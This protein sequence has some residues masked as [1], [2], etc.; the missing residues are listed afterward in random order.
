M[1]Q[2]GILYQLL[3]FLL[4]MV[5]GAALC[6]IYDIFRIARIAKK[7]SRLLLFMQ[8]IAFA[9]VCAVLIFF[10]QMVRSSGEVRWFILTGALCGFAACRVTV[11]RFFML[12]SGVIIRVIK[13][14]IEL[15]NKLLICPVTRVINFILNFLIL[16]LKSALLYVRMMFVRCS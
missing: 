2:N 3:T 14:I 11:S 8:D 10:M 13:S 9:L 16:R 6:L 15:V 7:P 12:I 4:S 5:L 1:E